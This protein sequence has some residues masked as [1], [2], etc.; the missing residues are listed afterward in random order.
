MCWGIETG[1]GWYNIVDT[2]CSQIQWHIDK[3]LANHEDWKKF[4]LRQLKLKKNLAVYGFTTMVVMT[5]LMGWCGW[6][7]DCPSVP[8]KIV[9]HRENR[10]IRHGLLPCVK[11][12][13]INNANW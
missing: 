6:P 8:V 5:L 4:K 9:G 1:D 13:E 11:I 2:L 12:A 3:N 7:K 10:A